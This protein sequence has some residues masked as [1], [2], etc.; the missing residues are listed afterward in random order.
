MLAFSIDGVVVHHGRRGT[1][2]ARCP[3]H[4]DTSR[5][6]P[7]EVPRLYMGVSTLRLHPVTPWR[8]TSPRYPGLADGNPR[9]KVKGDEWYKI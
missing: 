8:G 1:A 2:A 4:R 9:T 5:R 3:R 6:G 7:E